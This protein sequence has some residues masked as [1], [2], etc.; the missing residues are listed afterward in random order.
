[1]QISY[2]ADALIDGYAYGGP[3]C[4]SLRSSYGAQDTLPGII[5]STNL[6]FNLQFVAVPWSGF[7][8]TV[9]SVLHSQIYRLLSIINS[10]VLLYSIELIV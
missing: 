6:V 5:L 1:M 2:L 3:T 7:H 9:A 8:N 10:L 4:K